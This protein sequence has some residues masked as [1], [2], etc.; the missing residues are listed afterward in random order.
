M[1]DELLV[2]DYIYGVLHSPDYRRTYAQFLKIDFPRIP[3]PA[4]PEVFAHVAEKGGQLRRLHLMEDAAIGQAPYPFKGASVS[5]VD[6]VVVKPAFSPLPFRGGAKP[7]SGG[8]VG[9]VGQTLRQPDKPHPNPVEPLG[10]VR[11]TDPSTPEGEGLIGRVLINPD[12]YFEN[13]PAVAWEFHIGGYQPAQ[14]WLK[15]R[16]GRALSFDDVMHYQKIIKILTE[17]DRIMKEIKL[18]L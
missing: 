5:G 7:Q 10:S 8:G 16:K 9:S 1:P 4:S 14:K 18:P 15:D 6:N 17:T 3:Y 13:V 2:F 11:G 12:Q